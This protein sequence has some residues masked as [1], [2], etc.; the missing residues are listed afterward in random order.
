M[1]EWRSIASILIMYSSFKMEFRY[2]KLL[3]RV[4]NADVPTVRVE[5]ET[6]PLGWR[7]AYELYWVAKVREWDLR[8]L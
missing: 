6:N 4:F 3:Q 7:E 1:N 5:E 8:G 2:D